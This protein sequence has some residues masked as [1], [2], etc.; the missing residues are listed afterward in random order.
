M[1]SIINK[2]DLNTSEMRSVTPQGATYT[3][4]EFFENNISTY[5]NF[6]GRWVLSSGSFLCLVVSNMS[7][8]VRFWVKLAAFLFLNVYIE[9][10]VYQKL[11]CERGLASYTFPDFIWS[12][13][14][15]GFIDQPI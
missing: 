6:P 2:S 7:T 10:C 15:N 3:I 5:E 4:A 13:S 9:T 14:L 12:F 1:E 11:E 8:L